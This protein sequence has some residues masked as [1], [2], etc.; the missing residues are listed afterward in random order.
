MG[1]EA[2]DVLC[3]MKEE[4]PA[5]DGSPTVSAGSETPASSA[6]TAKSKKVMATAL[7]CRRPSDAHIA[8]Q[9]R[10]RARS[11]RHCFSGQPFSAA[12]PL[13]G[14]QLQRAESRAADAR[15]RAHPCADLPADAPTNSCA[16]QPGRSAARKRLA[17]DTRRRRGRELPCPPGR[18]VVGCRDPECTPSLRLVQSGQT[19]RWAVRSNSLPMCHLCA[20]QQ[21]VHLRP[22]FYS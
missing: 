8:R 2:D 4:A 20:G 7:R 5:A 1:P 14:S 13:V 6:H 3:R 11:T 19:G 12:P 16:C 17:M 22:V 21:P 18:N 15:E 10:I 9:L